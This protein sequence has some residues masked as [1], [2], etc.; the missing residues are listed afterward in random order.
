MGARDTR[1]ARNGE[2]RIAY[3]VAG[4]GSL[5]LAVVPGFLSNLDLQ[6]E[7]PGFA[8]LMRR[9]T[10]FARVILVDK[11]GMGLSDRIDP[12][13]L[14]GVA[15]RVE[16]IRSVLDAAGSGRAAVIGIADGA[17]LSILLAA[18]YPERVRALI[19][20]AGYA[21]FAGAVVGGADPDG[22][23]TEI[24]SGWG[25]GV[26]L[27]R[28]APGR[29]EDA[30]FRDWWAR[31]ERLSAT[32]TS[33]AALLR[34]NAAIDVRQ[35]LPGVQAPTLVLHRMNDAHV[36]FTSAEFL[37]KRIANAQL[38][39]LPGRDHPIFLGEVDRIVDRIEQFLTGSPPLPDFERVLA[40]LLVARLVNPE[41]LAARHGDREWRERVDRLLD[42]TVTI[43]GRY[44]GQAI[45]LDPGHIV[46]RFEGPARAIRCAL[47]LRDAAEAPELRP[48]VG[49]HVGEVEVYRDSIAGIVLYAAERIAAGAEAGDI[50]VSG[51]AAEL[52]SGSGLRFVE[53][54]GER[55]GGD[56]G[57][58]LYAVAAEQHLEP[59]AEAT[60]TPQLDALTFREREILKLIADGL[61]N[62]AIA[63]RLHL[64]EHTVKRHVAN[65]L[66]KLDLPTRAAA[67][68]LAG[69]ART[70]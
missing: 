50:L 68:A 7:D 3:Q 53:R 35:S 22:L 9:L 66:L 67:A 17:A 52:V 26:T 38:V 37:A 69:R 11:R 27:P 12:H 34:A 19:L 58:R 31:L 28:F 46:V 61:S 8:H 16:D 60:K 2:V 64:S 54:E 5:D 23:L 29:G 41:R 14:P 48:A 49:V 24:E 21:H 33:A 55:N 1:Y 44:G 20:Y 42:G 51:L 4:Q 18:S 13:D 47:A 57:L 59:M 62:P 10:G 40:T 56:S 43:L 32:P 25:K 63:D 45:D 36:K 6:A 39:E 30:R 65:I 15:E 70:S